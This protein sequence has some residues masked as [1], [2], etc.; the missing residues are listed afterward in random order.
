MWSGLVWSGESGDSGEFGDSGPFG[1]FGDPSGPFGDPTGP[2]WSWFWRTGERVN[3]RTKL[4]EKVLK[5][6]PKKSNKK[7]Q[8]EAKNGH[9]LSLIWTFLHL[10]EEKISSLN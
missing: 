5:R 7:Y 1:L 4:F 9:L 8:C 6:R 3:K 10:A 2:F